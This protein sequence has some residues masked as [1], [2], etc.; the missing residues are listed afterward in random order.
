L[1][2]EKT[3]LTLSNHKSIVIHNRSEIVA[4]FQWKA[5]VTQEEEDLQKLRLV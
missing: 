5:F 1:T 3:Y 2:V 4:H